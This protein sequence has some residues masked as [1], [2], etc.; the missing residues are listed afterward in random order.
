MFSFNLKLGSISFLN[1]NEVAVTDALTVTDCGKSVHFVNAYSLVSAARNSEHFNAI[2]RG[3]CFCDSKPLSWYSNLVG[4]SV[5]QLR[6]SDFLLHGL[7]A[8][9]SVRHL[10]VG[11]KGLNGEEFRKRV[12][13]FT[14]KHIDVQFYTP[15][16][17]DD[18]DL[19]FEIC[20]KKLVEVD[21]HFVWLAIGTPKQDLL[22]S[23]LA[24]HFPRNFFCVGA[25]VDFMSGAIR[26]SPKLISNLGV[27]WLFRLIQEPKRLWKRYLIG[28][29][30]FLLLAI[31]DA[32]GKLI[33]LFQS[34]Q[35]S[36][37]QPDE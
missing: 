15:P 11:G 28:N 33:K 2:R 20:A 18:I 8:Q 13:Q 29:I 6:G 16:Y 7:T 22:A 12:L 14:G 27:E 3:I 31:G 34:K 24:T 30:A 35:R 26:E 9:P 1:P 36:K 32:T 23:R 21:P 10:V 5:K 17:T 37:T 4:S 19:L 25:A